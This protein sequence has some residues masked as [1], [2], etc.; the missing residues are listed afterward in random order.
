M[1]IGQGRMARAPQP[2]A[3]ALPPLV[4]GRPLPQIALAAGAS[5]ATGL[6]DAHAAVGRR[7]RRRRGAV[8][9]P[10]GVSLPAPGP[11]LE[12]AARADLVLRVRARRRHPRAPVE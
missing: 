11:R 1:E 12:D 6:L 7:A 8:R 5:G 2:P 9:A 4:R 3:P 10:D